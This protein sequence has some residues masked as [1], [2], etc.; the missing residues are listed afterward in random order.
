MRKCQAMSKILFY[1][2]PRYKPKSGTPSI[3][4]SH[5]SGL[6]GQGC[7]LHFQNQDRELIFRKLVFPYPN[8]DQYAK[9]QSGTCSTLQSSKCVL[10][11]MDVFCTFKIKIE[12]WYSENWC[13][14][15]QCPYPNQGQYAKPLSGTCSIL[16]SSKCVLKSMDVLCTFKIKKRNKI[17]NIGLSKTSDHIQIK[18][19][20]PN[21]SYD[22]PA[23]PKAQILDLKD[24][25]VLCTFKTKKESKTWNNVSSKNNDQT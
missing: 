21:P 9:P 22:P 2:K 15:V 16:R 6:K 5:N 23:S 12:S 20:I 19:K 4:Q 1:Q 17:Q 11:S 24:I 25:G 3:I 14:K 8:Q 18:I 13:I 10:K 7:S